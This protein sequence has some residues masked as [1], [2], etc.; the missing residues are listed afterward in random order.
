MRFIGGRFRFSWSKLNRWLF[1]DLLSNHNLDYFLVEWNV[2]SWSL[3]SA[4][5]LAL[6]FAAGAGC[7]EFASAFPFSHTGSNLFL[8]PTLSCERKRCTLSPTGC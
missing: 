4:S 6:S 3:L 8:I 7:P 2:H 1:E 5:S